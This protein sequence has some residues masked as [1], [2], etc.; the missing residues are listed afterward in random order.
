MKWMIASDFHGSYTFTKKLFECYEK[1]KCERLLILGDIL[2]HG[3][4]NDLPEG[5]APKKVIELINQHVE[6]L[7]CVQGNCDTEVDQMVLKLPILNSSMLISMN[8]RVIYACHGHRDMPK[9]KQGDI[10]LQG[11]THIP[12]CEWIDGILHLNPGSISIPKEGSWHGYMILEDNTFT[13]KD[14]GGKVHLEFSL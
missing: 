12:Q 14:L 10:Y 6:E 3:P 8:D 13:W 11:H 2:Y 1:E 5:Y 4:R 7:F 9:L